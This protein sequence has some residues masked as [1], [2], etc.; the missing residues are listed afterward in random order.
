MSQ[1]HFEGEELIE[2]HSKD[3]QAAADHLALR[4]K[5]L[6][7]AMDHLSQSLNPMR[8]TWVASPSEAGAAAG[9]AEE[10]LGTA[11]D[12]IIDLINEF[13]VEVHSSKDRQIKRDSDFA[14]LFRDGH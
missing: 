1:M 3:M 10:R 14:Q 6:G 13:A 4:A 11:V 12:N 9:E 7:T 5:A 8:K 2:F